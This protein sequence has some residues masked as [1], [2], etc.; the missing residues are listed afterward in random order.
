[1]W[2]DWWWVHGARKIVDVRSFHARLRGTIDQLPSV[3]PLRLYSGRRRADALGGVGEHIVSTR[4]KDI[5]Q[6]FRCGSAR[7][8]PAVVYDRT[9]S[10]VLSSDYWCVIPERGAGPADKTRGAFT[11][12]VPGAWRSNPYLLNTVGIHFDHDTWTGLDVFKLA[13]SSHLL[14]TRGVAAALGQAGLVGVRISDV[15]DVGREM[16]ESML[17]RTLETARREGVLP[18]DEGPS[19]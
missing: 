5:L 15:L 2:G 12:V 17:A 14:L 18:R 7:F 8:I 3:F 4:V 6:S 1:M 16:R 10:S 13:D 9:E 11:L 19:P